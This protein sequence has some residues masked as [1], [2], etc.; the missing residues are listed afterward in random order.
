MLRLWEAKYN[1]EERFPALYADMEQFLQGGDSFEAL[2][3]S[4]SIMNTGLKWSWEW[5]SPSAQADLATPAQM[6]CLTRGRDKTY[7]KPRRL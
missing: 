4:A 3:L 7:W 5:Q 2:A 6:S 1:P